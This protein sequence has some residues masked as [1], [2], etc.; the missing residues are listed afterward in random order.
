MTDSPVSKNQAETTSF[1][2]S[3]CGQVFIT[4]DNSYSPLSARLLQHWKSKQS[5]W[6]NHLVCQR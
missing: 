4:L 3:T 6:A 2:C 5:Q 1:T